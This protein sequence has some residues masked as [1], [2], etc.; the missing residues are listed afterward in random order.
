MAWVRFQ[1]HPGLGRATALHRRWRHDQAGIA[2][3]RLTISGGLARVSA[4]CQEANRTGQF[5]V[6]YSQTRF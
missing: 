6:R 5:L 3:L 2:N 1:W 4:I